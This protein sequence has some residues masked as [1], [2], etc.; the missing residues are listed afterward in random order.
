MRKGKKA[1][2]ALLAMTLCFSLAGMVYGSWMAGVSTE[3]LL[4]MDSYKASIVEDYDPPQHVD[5]SGEVTKRV[6][7]RN[8][9][10]VPILVRVAVTKMFGTRS[11]NGEFTE[12]PSL[13]TDVIELHF[14]DKFWEKGADGWFYYRDILR[15]KETTK[16]P[17][18]ESYTLSQYAGNEYKGK[19][20]QILI[21]MESIQAEGGASSLWKTAPKET[22]RVEAEVPQ[23]QDT[24]VIFLG[25]ER[26][27]SFAMDGTD[28][29]SAFKNLSP[30]CA[31]LQRIT[32]RN[33]SAEDVEIF[34][35]AE[36]AEQ[37]SMTAE[38]RELVRQLLEKY[39]VIEVTEEGRV[40]YQGPVSNENSM[41][42]DI[43]LGQFSAGSGK[44]LDVK[45]SLSPQ[46]DN[47]Y[48]KLTGKV[49]WIFSARG[50][51]GTVLQ[52]T[53][54][55]TGDISYPAMWAAIFAVSGITLSAALLLERKDR[56]RSEN[57]NAEEDP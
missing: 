26:G 40:I 53:A 22:R 27:F 37:V 28:L 30:G 49:Q 32:V 19:E 21:T 16:E 10:T 18:M 56:R 17:L 14:H 20:A 36:K 8:D 42:T 44:E 39:A 2:L 41:R 6:N 52:A 50:E 35:H 54:P 33:E 34:L 38:Q 13:D 24:G 12:D 3:N 55:Q 23:A 57:E 15:A 11:D 29:F 46:M 1:V 25:R 5:P 9:G 4:T 48:Q 47:R 43:S 7:V 45:L 31:R 51:D